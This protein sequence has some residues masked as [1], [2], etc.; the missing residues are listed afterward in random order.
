MRMGVLEKINGTRY[1]TAYLDHSR[2]HLFA[3]PMGNTVF[4]EG[5]PRRYKEFG[6]TNMQLAGMLEAP[7]KFTIHRITCALFRNKKPIPV[8]GEEEIW[9]SLTLN[10]EVLGRNYGKWPVIELADPKCVV[11]RLP[12][13]G[14]S[15]LIEWVKQ[16]PS[17]IFALSEPIRIERQV[18]FS[19]WVDVPKPDPSVELRVVFHGDE[20]R[21]GLTQ[22]SEMDFSIP[23]D[24]TSVFRG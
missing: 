5:E 10:L 18:C 22:P 6:D 9:R 16:F 4:V 7:I 19:V 11:G 24:F 2:T 17:L 20:Y 1:D 21:P 12:E 23:P 14:E 8:F 13:G 15:A 3:V